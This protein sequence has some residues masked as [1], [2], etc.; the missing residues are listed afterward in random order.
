MTQTEV[1]RVIESEFRL[2]AASI[3]QGEDTV[4]HTAILNVQVPNLIPGAGIA[5]VSYVFGYQSHTLMEVSIVWSRAI[6][7]KT[8]PQQIYQN[9]ETLQQYFATEGFPPQRSSGN[10]ATSDG[11]ILFRATDPVG[12]AVGLILSGAMT[13]DP[14]TNRTTLQP[15]ALT[16]AYVSD[17]QH[18]DIFQLSKGSF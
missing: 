13:K 14:K 12:N 10:I 9:G 18:P 1:R 17:P 7:P 15:G 3:K 5:N 11:V 6:D 8:T 4:Q 2:P 16:L